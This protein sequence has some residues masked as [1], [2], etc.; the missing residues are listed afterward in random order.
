LKSVAFVFAIINLPM[1][2]FLSSYIINLLKD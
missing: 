1:I 2:N